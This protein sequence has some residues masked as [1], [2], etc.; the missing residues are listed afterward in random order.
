MIR[1][2]TFTNVGIV[3]MN[4]L[5]IAFNLFA[6]FSKRNILI[7]LRTLRTE[8]PDKLSS[9]KNCS[10]R[11]PITIMKSKRFHLSKKKALCIASI[12]MM[13]SSPNIK[14]KISSRIYIAALALGSNFLATILSAKAFR[15]I[16]TI[17][18]VS[19]YL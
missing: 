17:M 6:Y 11:P 2:K 7:I 13:D 12:L 5:K 1:A 3:L 8:R 16:I 9:C 4:E 15:K 19:K 18:K 14:R 10:Q